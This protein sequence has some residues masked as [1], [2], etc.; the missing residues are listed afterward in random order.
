MGLTAPSLDTGMHCSPVTNLL[1]LLHCK[2]HS[3]CQLFDL[4]ALAVRQEIRFTENMQR[5]DCRV[6]PDGKLAIFHSPTNTTF[7]QVYDISSK[8]VLI[9]NQF[10]LILYTS[11]ILFD[12]APDGMEL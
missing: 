5:S 6:S 8:L 12:F 1:V 9:N 7:L 3:V 2:H 10:A 11:R 4:D